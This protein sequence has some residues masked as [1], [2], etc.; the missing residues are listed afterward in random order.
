MRKEYNFELENKF[1]QQFEINR[2][3]KIYFQIEL[4]IKT[5]HVKG[6]IC[7]FG[8]FKANSLTR[9]ILLRDIYVKNKKIFAYDLVSRY[10]KLKLAT[11]T[12]F[13]ISIPHS[14]SDI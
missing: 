5:L 7:E 6:D 12:G 3:S 14:H 8:V 13:L 2:A 11:E 1:F 4:F 10:S 9:L